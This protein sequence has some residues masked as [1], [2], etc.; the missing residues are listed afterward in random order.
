MHRIYIANSQNSPGQSHL[1]MQ[2]GAT[3]A[4]EKAT[5]EK[6]FSRRAP[7]CPPREPCL[8]FARK[9]CIAYICRVHTA[10]ISQIRGTVL[11]KAT[12]T[13]CNRHTRERLLSRRAPACPPREPCFAVFGMRVYRGTSLIRNRHPVGPHSETMPRLRCRF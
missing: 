10:Y 12:L 6:L 3:G 2:H 4:L 7:A 11:G 8:G 5:R 13:W 1:T 9:V